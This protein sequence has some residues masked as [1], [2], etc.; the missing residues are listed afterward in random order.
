MFHLYLVSCLHHIAQ[1]QRTILLLCM[2]HK[3]SRQYWHMVTSVEG[4]VWEDGEVIRLCAGRPPWRQGD[5]SDYSPD[6]GAAAAAGGH[7]Q[8]R[9]GEHPPSM[10][11]CKRTLQ[12]PMLKGSLY[13]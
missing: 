5:A 8:A 10:H 13:C 9:G 3:E 7:P 6:G 4:A 2:L 1:Y 12:L 11:H